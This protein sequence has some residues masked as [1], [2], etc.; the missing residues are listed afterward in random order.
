[1]TFVLP[2][3]FFGILFAIPFLGRKRERSPARRPIAIGAGALFLVFVFSLLG[4][5][6]KETAALKKTDPTI[7][8]GRAIYAK[9]ACAGCHRIHGEG[10]QVGPDLSFV[11]DVR[12]HDWLIAHFNNPQGMVP[13]SIMPPVRLGN[14]EL[15]ELTRYMQSLKKSPT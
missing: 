3:L 11:G 2:V 15:E 1:V 8:R 14:P 6:M 7:E 4:L 5:A 13:G 12:D 10:A 9:L